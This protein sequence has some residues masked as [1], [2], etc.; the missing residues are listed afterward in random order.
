MRKICSFYEQ[1]FT[2]LSES[3]LWISLLQN[4]IRSGWTE[5]LLYCGTVSSVSSIP[6]CSNAN[7]RYKNVC[8][9]ICIYSFF[10]LEKKRTIF[11]FENFLLSVFFQ[12]SYNQSNYHAKFWLSEI[13]LKQIYEILRGF[14]K[15]FSHKII[16]ITMCEHD[17]FRFCRNWWNYRKPYVMC[18]MTGI[19]NPALNTFMIKTRFKFV[20]ESTYSYELQRTD[21]MIILHMDNGYQSNDIC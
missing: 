6:L 15:K 18:Q 7:P 21:N 1:I 11:S 8:M 16:N 2:P 20:L 3:P 14:L 12:F 9:Y 5:N 19:I 17:L 4:L 10:T 13:V